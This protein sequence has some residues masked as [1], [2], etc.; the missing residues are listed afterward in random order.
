MLVYDYRSNQKVDQ[1]KT[2]RGV[3]A[4]NGDCLE[5]GYFSPKTT[6]VFVFI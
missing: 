6:D 4:I 5:Y 1:D 3:I 2:Y